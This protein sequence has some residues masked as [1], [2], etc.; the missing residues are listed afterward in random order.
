MHAFVRSLAAARPVTGASVKL[1]ARNNEILATA[2]TDANGY[3]R[4]PV[5]QTRGE[6]GLQPAILV[7]ENGAGEYAFLD[8]T[9]NAFDLSDR[10][11]KGR[12]APGPLDGYVY[13]DRGVYR[14]GEDVFLTAL[15]R[16][17]VGHAATLPVTLIVTRP[18][19]VEHRRFTLP[20]RASAAAPRRCRSAAAS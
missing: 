11:V 16:D 6:G 19:G 17:R 13:T 12:E 1:V 10:G 4:F 8:L 5:G 9:T 18:D 20:T 14:P 2:T 3:A 7:A 15:V